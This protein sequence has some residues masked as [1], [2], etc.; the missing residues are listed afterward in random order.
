MFCNKCGNSIPDN[1]TFCPVCGAS[2]GMGNW[3][4]YGRRAKKSVSFGRAIS[5]FFS[6]YVDF[7]GRSRRSEY[8]WAML[9]CNL[10]SFLLTA[11]LG[12]LAY[13]W[14]LL[15]FLPTLAINVRRLHDISKSGWWYLLV[16]IPLVG[17]I[18]L[19]VFDCQDS[20]PTNNKWGRSPKYH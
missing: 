9:F 16:L 18:I 15:I 5:L 4:N 14:S 13:I 8:W 1:A 20:T 17:G 6:H 10:V 3:D 12:D 11:I 2:A 7:H 19:L